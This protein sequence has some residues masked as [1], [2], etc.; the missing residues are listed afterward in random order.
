MADAKNTVDAVH[1]LAEAV[2]V[3]ALVQPAATEIGQ[4]LGRSVRVA[5]GPLRVLVWG[6][7]QIEDFL[8]ASVTEKLRGVRPENIVTPA[9]TIAG[10]AI[11]ALRFAGHDET[12]R[13]MYATLL[14]TSMDATTSALAHPSFVETIR[15][16]TPDE[17][18]IIERIGLTTDRPFLTVKDGHSG[19][20]WDREW[21]NLTLYPRQIAMTRPEL[22][23][24]YLSNLSRL[25]L[26]DLNVHAMI[27]DA[28]AYDEIRESAE[29]ARVIE[30][31]NLQE[32]HFPILDN[33]II[34]LTPYGDLFLKACV[35]DHPR[36]ALAPGDASFSFQS[37]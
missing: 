23:Q 1:G 29:V 10:P 7:E 12:L 8:Y 9:P 4:T 5:L 18:R 33:G 36:D 35:F 3:P 20:M 31:I 24:T 13:E 16:L 11:E 17:A 2:G 27:S 28:S 19:E 14:A 32:G 37:S 22:S 6:F 34:K 30:E 25:G 26:I 15:Q 21:A